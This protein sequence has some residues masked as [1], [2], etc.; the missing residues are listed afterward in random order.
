M[1][2]GMDG[3]EIGK[4]EIQKCKEKGEIERGI[5]G[6]AWTKEGMKKEG[7]EKEREGEC[8][9]RGMK[10]GYHKHKVCTFHR[11]WKSV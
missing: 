8:G 9:G 1:E 11:G 7:I 2:T 6:E 3:E 10:S 4:E 5:Q